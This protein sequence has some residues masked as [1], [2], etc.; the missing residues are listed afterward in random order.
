MIDYVSLHAVV[1]IPKKNFSPLVWS[2]VER[3]T[4]NYYFKKIGTVTLRYF[5][6]TQRF[7]ITGKLI[8]LF[9]DTQVLNVDDIYGHDTDR[10]V[11]EANEYL[12]QLAG[13]RIDVRTFTASRIDYCFN[14]ETPFVQAYLDLLNHAFKTTDTGQRRNF[15]IEHKTP[16]SVYIKT[17]SDYRRNTRTNYTLN[18]YDK[19]DWIANQRKRGNHISTEDDDFAKDI[20]RL[21][22]QAG[23]VLLNSISRT[24]NMDR[25]FG[26][27]FSYEIAFETISSVYKRI[28]H[29]DMSLDYYTYQTAKQLISS[30]KA[31]QVLELAAEH[32]PIS[33][34]AYRYAVTLIKNKG[35]FP[36]AF[37][38]AGF[39]VDCLPNPLALIDDKITTQINYV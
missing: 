38:P 16:G 7:L 23:Y 36:Y 22:V 8:T 35:I 6:E 37:L 10:F 33:S 24:H 34:T 18:F 15:S 14:V 4:G 30:P 5:P 29:S 39:D 3:D 25:T 17:A 2:F 32:H 28:F 26:N 27:L 12:S 13:I 1:H 19:T 20:L 11:S 21:E 9:Y 31:R